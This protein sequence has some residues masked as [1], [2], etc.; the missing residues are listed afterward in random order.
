MRASRRAGGVP[1]LLPAAAAVRAITCGMEIRRI[2]MSELIIT[3]KTV[4]HR[5]PELSR[6]GLPGLGLAV[7]APEA[8]ARA[9]LFVKPGL[10]KSLLS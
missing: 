8:A 6:T 7:T 9:V 10:G 5:G 2:K 1:A 3:V 4:L